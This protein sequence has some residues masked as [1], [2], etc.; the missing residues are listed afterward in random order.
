MRE[1]DKKWVEVCGKLN[2][3]HGRDLVSHERCH[4][5]M[6]ARYPALPFLN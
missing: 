1:K 6:N 4:L 2:G 5:L 3:M